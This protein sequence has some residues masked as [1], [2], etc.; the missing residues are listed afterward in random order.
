[1]GI[2]SISMASCGVLEHSNPNRA[3]GRL[4]RQSRNSRLRLIWL[5]ASDQDG[6]FGDGRPE[7][8][9]VNQLQFLFSK[10]F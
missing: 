6:G 8:V 9:L 2:F 7:D 5:P 10:I 3:A 4:R 1:M